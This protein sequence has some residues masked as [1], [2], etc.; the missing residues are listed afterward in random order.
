MQKSTLLVTLD[1]VWNEGI[2]CVQFAINDRQAGL[3]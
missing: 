1:A 3:V 2:L